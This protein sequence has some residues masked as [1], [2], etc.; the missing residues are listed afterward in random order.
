[1]VYVCGVYVW[2]VCEVEHVCVCEREREMEYVC[3]MYVYM[4]EVGMCV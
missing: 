2:Y 3:G 1:M 4:C